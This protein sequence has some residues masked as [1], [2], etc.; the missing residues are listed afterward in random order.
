MTE[1]VLLAGIGG[2]GIVTAGDLL[3][4]AAV[5]AGCQVK[6]AEVHGMAQRG[7]S[8]V[9]HV[10]ISD[11]G[12]IYSP[13]IADGA[14]TWLVALEL[15][16]GLRWLWML[17]PEGRVVADG[18]RVPPTSVTLGGVPY[19][20]DPEAP[21]AQRGLILRATEM[22]TAE[23]TPRAANTAVIGALS[24]HLGIPRDAWGRALEECIRPR[25]REANE[26]LFEAGRDAARRAASNTVAGG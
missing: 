16:E 13:M 7:G 1:D 3:A 9:S 18:R 21:L 6:K 19:P 12:P 25:H 4:H 22:A 10:R 20:K 11:S 26:R 17:A 24:V 23:G 8:V 5:A 2:Q 14:A 15:L